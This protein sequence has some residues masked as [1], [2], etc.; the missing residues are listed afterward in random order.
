MGTE[1]DRLNSFPLLGCSV[2]SRALPVGPWWCLQDVGRLGLI[3]H[4]GPR[5]RPVGRLEADLAT[6]QGRDS[7]TLPATA[8]AEGGLGGRGPSRRAL[9]SPVG[10]NGSSFLT[11]SCTLCNLP[12]REPQDTRDTWNWPPHHIPQAPGPRWSPQSFHGSHSGVAW[13]SLVHLLA[14][15]DR[16]RLDRYVR[17]SLPSHR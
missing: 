3:G 15:P 12:L 13:G 9:P 11:H 7:A 8:S 1:H 6:S 5:R 4:R 14:S 2:N 17:T 16:E 10:G